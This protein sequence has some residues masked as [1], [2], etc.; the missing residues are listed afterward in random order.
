MAD[1]HSVPSSLRWYVPEN[2]MQGTMRNTELSVLFLCTSG[3]TTGT[4]WSSRPSSA[5]ASDGRSRRTRKSR[6]AP[7]CRGSRCRRL[8]LAPRAAPAVRGLSRSHPLFQTRPLRPTAR[9][10]NTS[11]STMPPTSSKTYAHILCKYISDKL[12]WGNQY[13]TLYTILRRNCW[14]I[15]IYKCTVYI[16]YVSVN[17]LRLIQYANWEYIQMD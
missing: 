6:S 9:G 15:R 10:S 17:N 1:V 11:T 14:N 3:R 7:V 5:S 4:A 8:A 16:L 12:R 2:W 13:S